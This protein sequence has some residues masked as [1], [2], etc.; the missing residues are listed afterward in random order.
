MQLTKGG[1]MKSSKEVCEIKRI[2]LKVEDK[3]ISLTPEQ[4]KKLKVVLDELFGKEIV[5]EVIREIHEHHDHYP[6]YNP[7]R[8]QEPIAWWGGNAGQVSYS[9]ENQSVNC[10]L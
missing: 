1:E 7:W 8:W 10:S 5:K 3:E 6:Y 9:A 2:V 4:A